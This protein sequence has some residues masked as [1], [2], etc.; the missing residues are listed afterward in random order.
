MAD[1]A[2]GGVDMKLNLKIEEMME[3]MAGMETEE[4][5]AKEVRIRKK[6][7]RNK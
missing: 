5:D 7:P 6:E 1:G 3:G 2:E 4:T